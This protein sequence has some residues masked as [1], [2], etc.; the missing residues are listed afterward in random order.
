MNTLQKKYK[1]IAIDKLPSKLKNGLKKLKEKTN[2]FESD[3]DKLM[4]IAEQSL[5]KVI[6]N[7]KVKRPELIIK[8]KGSATK[9]D[10]KA[11]KGE[12]DPD[13]TIKERA[14]KIKK[15]NET[16][17][18]AEERAK[19]QKEEEA[20]E[21]EDVQ[22][23]ADS[24]SQLVKDFPKLKGFNTGSSGRTKSL[25][26]DA[27]RKASPRGK[28]VSRKGWKNQ[29]GASKGGRTYYENRE[30][31]TDR[32][33]PNYPKGAP[34]LEKGGKLKDFK[35]G[36]EVK[37]KFPYFESHLEYKGKVLELTNLGAKVEY[38]NDSGQTVTTVEPYNKLIKLKKG[39]KIK[40]PLYDVVVKWDE[41]TPWKLV[42]NEGL[43]KIE[44]EKVAE[45]F[46]KAKESFKELKIEPAL[47]FE[48]GGRLDAE[49]LRPTE[50]LSVVTK[51]GKVIDYTDDF[52]F[53]SGLYISET[54][55]KKQ[56][57]NNDEQLSLFEKGGKLPKHAVYIP[58]YN[59]DFVETY[60][61]G[62]IKGNKLY[63]GIWFKSDKQQKLVD[64]AVASGRFKK[65][66]PKASPRILRGKV[67]KG[68]E[69][70][71][72]ENTIEKTDKK[73]YAGLLKITIDGKL[74]LTKYF[75][76]TSDSTREDIEKSIRGYLKEL[77]Y[78]A[79]DLRGTNKIVY[80]KDRGVERIYRFNSNEEAE[81]FEKIIKSIQRRKYE[82]GGLT[83]SAKSAHTREHKYVNKS[84]DYEERYAKGK[85]R[86]RYKKIDEQLKAR[87]EKK[88]KKLMADGGY[89]KRKIYKYGG[90][91]GREIFIVN[92]GTTFDKDKYKAV[93]QDYD[94]DGRANIDDKDPLNKKNQGQ[95]EQVELRK[96][97]E[98]LLDTKEKLDVVMDDV[99]GDMDK[100]A[101]KDAKIY[102][103][104]KTPY[105]IIKK[106]ID[107]RMT[108]PKK[109]L[110][111]LIGTTLVVA[112]RDD[113]E[114]IRK[115]VESGTFGEVIDFDDYYKN[116][117]GGYT[118]YHYIVV[119]NGMPVEIQ[120]K[121]ERVKKLNEI[122][123]EFYKDGTLS[124]EGNLKVSKL[125]EKADKGDKTAQKEVD[126]LFADSERLKDMITVDKKE[127]GGV[128][129]KVKDRYF[130]FIDG[131]RHVVNADS[132][133]DAKKKLI[134]MLKLPKKKQ[135]LLSVM[136]DKGMKEQEFRFFEKGGK[137]N[138][139]K[140]ALMRDRKYL[141]V[142]EDYEVRYAK[143]RTKNRKRYMEKGG[144]LKNALMFK[145][146]ENLKAL[147]KKAE[148]ENKKIT[149]SILVETINNSG[150]I[151]KHK[152][153]KFR[154]TQ[155]KDFIYQFRQ[156]IKLGKYKGENL[157]EIKAFIN[158]GNQSKLV[159]SLELYQKAEKGGALKKYK[160]GD[161][162]SKD[163]DYEGM[164]KYG[165][166]IDENTSDEDLKKYAKSLSDVNYHSLARP[167]DNYFTAIS[168]QSKEFKKWN[169]I[170]QFKDELRKETA[171][172][173][174]GGRIK[175]ALMRD[176]KY[177][178]V[179]EDYEVRYAKRKTKNR[180][181]YMEKGGELQRDLFEDYENIPSSIRPMI[182]DYLEKFDEGMVDYN[183][184]KAL[185]E[186]V[187]KKGYTFDYGLDNEPFGLRKKGVNL[188]QIK[189][190]EDAP[191]DDV[192][193][194][195]KG[196]EVIFVD[197][198]NPKSP[199]KIWESRKSKLG[200]KSVGSF[201]HR[202][203]GKYVGDYYLYPLD[204]F[205]KKELKYIPIKKGEV[206]LRMETDNMLFD[207]MPL[208][209]VN[210]D[211]GRVYF[212]VEDVDPDN[213]KFE[214]A[215]ADVI[216]L[217]LDEKVK[218]LA[219]KFD[220]RIKP[221]KK[222]KNGG[223][224][225]RGEVD[226]ANYYLEGGIVNSSMSDEMKRKILDKDGKPKTDT[227]SIQLL[228]D[229]N[230]SLNQTKD[231]YY[232]STK[233]EYTPQRQKLHKKIINDVKSG[234]RCIE[235]DQPI[236]ILMGGSPASGKSTF[237]KKS[238]P[239]L[240]KDEILKIDADDIR[241]KLPEYQGW[242]APITHRETQDIVR[243]L[244]SDRVIGLP[245]KTDIIYDGTM[246]SVEKYEKLIKLLKSLGYKIF[247]VFIDNVPKEEIKRRALN[248]YKESG[249]F[250]PME[251][252]DSFFK[253]GKSSLNRIK[254]DVDGYMVVD[255]SNDYE[256]IER[257]GMK[258]P[259]KREYSKLGKPI[260]KVKSK[261]A[262]KEKGGKLYDVSG[263]IENDF[264]P[265]FKE[266]QKE[267]LNKI[268]KHYSEERNESIAPIV[269]VNKSKKYLKVKRDKFGIPTKISIDFLDKP[270]NVRLKFSKDYTDMSDLYDEELKEIM[271]NIAE[272]KKASKVV[273]TTDKKEKGAQTFKYIVGEEG[274]FKGGEFR[275][276]SH[277]SKPNRYT[278]IEL[279][280]KGDK[281]GK[282]TTVS[283]KDFE[284]YFRKFKKG[285]KLNDDDIGF[286][287]TGKMYKV[288]PKHKKRLKWY[289]VSP[290]IVKNKDNLL[291][292]HTKFT[293]LVYDKEK[294]GH[295][296]SAF[297][298]YK[299]DYEK[300]RKKHNI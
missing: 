272:D 275:I 300:W 256:V 184:T 68:V 22:E 94:K 30:N 122:S 139:P 296:S 128:V 196:G 264:L 14:E 53:L 87:K 116:P 125:I 225:K 270:S 245:C 135:S 86:E 251:V 64:E 255:G 271:E 59:I 191:D 101:P 13:D 42:N 206:L 220:D 230:L 18:E 262:K 228:T 224:M 214:R 192:K 51:D 172:Y 249:R 197:T 118:A 167:L 231:K 202:L 40:A 252:I 188:N 232:N 100:K 95:V 201:A 89:C 235:H 79:K 105:S 198:K 82:K 4:K 9:P 233:G 269:I 193:P 211:N 12:P 41:D 10:T 266:N 237:L 268:A 294:D 25:T 6:S 77:K 243:V 199:L 99:I 216:Y 284:A 31:R 265:A 83:G 254:D 280:D 15:E 63:N 137:I 69:A 75:P 286:N 215:S 276:V 47:P 33:A 127:E 152:E 295:V 35:V 200:Q 103:R 187:E 229:Y 147:I 292:L 283:Q 73:V 58:N 66:S 166:T 176:R 109:G 279:D 207:E 250:V 36:D 97:F 54:P 34:K 277:Q 160:L 144:S 241:A 91:T 112:N 56:S 240:L 98:K 239:Y 124:P 194:F 158:L 155:T 287:Y 165:E 267:N 213:I 119:K 7:L 298:K 136:S 205:D 168:N 84:E 71:I 159:K 107:K 148:K 52:E 203:N 20:E 123:H 274:M 96:S 115:T 273:P 134:D 174:K 221:I 257:G 210:I 162:Y 49:Y 57:E 76:A 121:T 173:K 50:I 48:K 154:K 290:N 61:D 133:Y 181:R 161:T 23:V 238:A 157:A 247:I 226:W 244:L 72:I 297:K 204:D 27:G 178:N 149:Y 299:D 288:V 132:L 208:V 190:F 150:E 163:F 164:L 217:S 260:S 2:N 70:R 8:V 67:P 65:I 219:P 153:I 179:D 130:G 113:L 222:A 291:G 104:T 177:L 209:K 285:G 223:L 246:T 138:R 114:K 37:L 11:P 29:Y 16:K 259:S 289:E 3:D 106:L 258:L 175:S 78:V 180:K 111:D 242:N 146:D 108:D 169:F 151:N 227:K 282:E 253:Q 212:M 92:E 261:T 88:R 263:L 248:R 185:L 183:D 93:F 38:K 218:E 45:A 32:L 74:A 1:S 186:K 17:A 281:L 62:T 55:I 143:G 131:K 140:S 142:D 46:A 293:A 102:A 195:A 81:T 26:R 126:E 170:N 80:V 156:I 28:R 39:G 117:L 21:R 44:A 5:D 110:T 182:E 236:A 24:L 120:V 60:D 19:D 129:G 278:I 90:E 43:T 141:N 145:L 189:G 171:I 234:L 85:K